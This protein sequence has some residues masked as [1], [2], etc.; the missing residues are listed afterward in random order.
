MIF[1][2]CPSN[3][4]NISNLSVDIFPLLKKLVRGPFMF[5]KRQLVF[6]LPET[7]K[8]ASSFSGTLVLHSAIPANVSF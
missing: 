1:H 5:R 7:G 4:L 3:N 8:A 6:E 2:F